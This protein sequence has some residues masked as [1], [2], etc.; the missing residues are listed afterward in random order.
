[1][2]DSNTPCCRDDIQISC[3]NSRTALT[4]SAKGSPC[5]ARVCP[6]LWKYSA[7]SASVLS[8]VKYSSTLESANSLA[9]TRSW[10]GTTA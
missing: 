3:L 9:L 8:P 10:S 1:M 7:M 6:S 4:S 2:A 5:T